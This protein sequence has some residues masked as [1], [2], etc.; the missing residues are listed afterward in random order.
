VAGQALPAASGRHHALADIPDDFKLTGKQEIQRQAARTGQPR[1]EKPAITRFLK[2]IKFPC[3]Y[4]DFE[5]FGTA[6][7]CSMAEAV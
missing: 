6:I 5:T 1:I 3:S 7:R 4:L 2:R